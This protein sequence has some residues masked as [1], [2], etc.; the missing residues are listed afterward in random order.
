MN[1]T[2]NVN[3]LQGFFQGMQKGLV[4]L[5]ARE[6]VIIGFRNTN[7]P[8]VGVEETDRGNNKIYFGVI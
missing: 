5:L 2:Q 7:R 8:F 1:S 6:S 3:I 4:S